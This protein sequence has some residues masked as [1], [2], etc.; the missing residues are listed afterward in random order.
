MEGE[1]KWGRD[2]KG[3]LGTPHSAQLAHAPIPKRTGL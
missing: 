2:G 1:K 3:G